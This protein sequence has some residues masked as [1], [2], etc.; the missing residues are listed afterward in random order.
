MLF[1]PMEYVSAFSRLTGLIEAKE[2]VYIA[3]HIRQHY[4]QEK[5]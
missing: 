1:V 4:L 2:V 5:L 3:V